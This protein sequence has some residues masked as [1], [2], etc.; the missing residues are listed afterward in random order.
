MKEE[1]PLYMEE[2]K[3]QLNRK[4]CYLHG[5]FARG[6]DVSTKK[7]QLRLFDANIG[8]INILAI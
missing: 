6:K 7:N 1:E 5:S 4:K 2:A 3:M 8:P